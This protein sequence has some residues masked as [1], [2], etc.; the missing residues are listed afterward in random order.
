M[1]GGG[2]AALAR[3]QPE[4][5]SFFSRP[6]AQEVLSASSAGRSGE[7]DRAAE[8]HVVETTMFVAAAVL[9]SLGDDQSIETFLVI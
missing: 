2:G 3:R 6:G 7:R 4:T 9:L 8:Q 5:L 1:A